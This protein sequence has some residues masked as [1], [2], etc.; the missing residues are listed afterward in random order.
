MT[1]SQKIVEHIARLARIELNAAEKSKFEKE[2]SAILDFVAKLN[3]VDV[4]KVEPLT[5]G[6]ELVNVMRDDSL[7]ADRRP[8]LGASPG[9]LVEAAPKKREGYV[10]VKAVFE[11]E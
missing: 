3:E 4:S 10:E 2:L 1:I 8:G 11:R 7:T 5:G 9:R 6:T